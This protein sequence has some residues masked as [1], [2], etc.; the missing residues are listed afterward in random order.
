MWGG[1]QL[2]SVTTDGFAEVQL[3]GETRSDEYPA[4]HVFL[5]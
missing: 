2:I 4:T 5:A 1:G 3:D